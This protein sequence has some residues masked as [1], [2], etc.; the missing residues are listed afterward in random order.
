ML[1][2]S[3]EE[4][5][6]PSILEEAFSEVP[7]VKTH[8][9]VSFDDTKFASSSSDS[10]ENNS[11]KSDS[12]GFDTKALLGILGSQAAE[13]NP[14][15]GTI[16]GLLNGEKPDI[17][18]LLPLLMSLGKKQGKENVKENTTTLDDYTVIS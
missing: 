7:H 17:I 5:T 14:E 8:A 2:R 12:S 10:S 13:S 11:D 1:N 15:I 4:W 18:S 3:V 6:E 9:Q 16:M